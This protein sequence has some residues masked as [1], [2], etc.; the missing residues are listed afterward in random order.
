MNGEYR[1]CHPWTRRIGR[2]PAYKG[3]YSCLRVTWAGASRHR[4]GIYFEEAGDHLRALFD[5]GCR[6]IIGIC[7]AG[8]QIRM[9]APILIDKKKLNRL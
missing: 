6:P 3:C 5:A 1:Y 2:R 9:L 8:I 7:A 4:C